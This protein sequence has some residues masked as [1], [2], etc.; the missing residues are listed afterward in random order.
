MFKVQ[1]KSTMSGE[2][3]VRK[4]IQKQGY[5]MSDFDVLVI[6]LVPSDEWVIMKNNGL[7]RLRF[8][9]NNVKYNKFINNWNLFYEEVH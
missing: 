4:S 5:K 9:G 2:V 6:Y 8:G 7:V 3:A 1:V